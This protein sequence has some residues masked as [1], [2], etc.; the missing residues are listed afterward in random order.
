LLN[1]IINA[2]QAMPEG[3]EIHL[4][5]TMSPVKD[6]EIIVTVRDTGCGIPAENLNRLFDPYFT[7]RSRGFGLGLSIVDKIIQEHGGRI[8]VQSTPGKGSTFK[9]YLL[10]TEG[11]KNA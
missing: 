7:T 4:S 6:N 8:E 2:L 11:A 9:L 1:L 10:L 5:T 3:G